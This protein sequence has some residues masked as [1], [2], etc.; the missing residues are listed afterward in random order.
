[1]AA[2]SPGDHV[3]VLHLIDVLP[4]S[5]GRCLH[6]QVRRT[7][8]GLPADWRHVLLEVGAGERRQP[9]LPE[10]SG[11]IGTMGDRM[12]ANGESLQDVLDSWSHQ[13][14]PFDLVH[15]WGTRSLH[16]RSTCD[17]GPPCIGTL[18]AVTLRGPLIQALLRLHG[19]TRLQ[20]QVG[21]SGMVKVLQRAGL[22]AIDL[23]MRPFG[24]DPPSVGAGHTA[25]RPAAWDADE[26]TVV[27]G[28]FG[29]PKQWAPL[30]SLMGVPA[31][32]ALVGRSVRVVAHPDI[33]GF[34][35][36]LSWLQS[37]DHGNLLVED[38][39]MDAPWSVLPHLDAILLPGTSGRRQES[40][41]ML[42]LVW[43]M[44]S[45]HPI[46]LGHGHP[47]A[48]ELAGHPDIFRSVDLDENGATRWLLAR[49]GAVAEPTSSGLCIDE[50]GWCER[51]RADYEAL[52]A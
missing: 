48:E 14:G 12:L 4:G 24:V 18:D 33:H 8:E 2:S 22:G 7:I 47:A 45:D 39:S 6:R 43:S 37:M 38:A 41:G 31:R 30:R 40:M 3:R 11:R 17:D 26:G 21:C 23:A 27:F 36:C 25:T 29:D 1:M 9:E 51:V 10:T 50:A 52:L 42:P 34:Q 46:L 32:L 20:V 49:T 16:L 35:Q 44:M 13:S 19:S 28:V 15:A 5:D